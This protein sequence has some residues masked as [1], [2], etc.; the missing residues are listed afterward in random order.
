MK[1]SEEGFAELFADEVTT[2]DA[3]SRKLEHPER[4]AMWTRLSLASVFESDPRRSPLGA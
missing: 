3:Y 2:V 4:A 1:G